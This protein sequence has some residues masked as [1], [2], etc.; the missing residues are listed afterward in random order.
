LTEVRRQLAGCKKNCPS[1]SIL[2][3]TS[4]QITVD[5]VT[6]SIGTLQI[7]TSQPLSNGPA[8]AVTSEAKCQ[9]GSRQAP[10]DIAAS[11]APTFEGLTL[12]HAPTVNVDAKGRLRTAPEPVITMHPP[13]PIQYS[14]PSPPPPQA[15]RTP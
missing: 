13:I 5:T 14:A 10:Q 12:T 6:G 1:Q 4:Q 11:A 9:C 15:C 2:I 7:S 3:G 8:R